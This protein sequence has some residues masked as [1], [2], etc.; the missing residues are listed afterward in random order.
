[1]NPSFLVN[2]ASLDPSARYV[3]QVFL[4]SPET[5]HHQLATVCEKKDTLNPLRAAKEL[6]KGN[7]DAFFFVPVARTS[8]N[9][10]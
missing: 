10:R 7:G 4:E 3:W 8:R 2:F 9:L 6:D 5:L 1:M